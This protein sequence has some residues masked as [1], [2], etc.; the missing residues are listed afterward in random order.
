LPMNGIVQDFRR[1][2][3]MLSFQEVSRRRKTLKDTIAA[4][5]LAIIFVGAYL[6]FVLFDL[7]K[8]G[9]ESNVLE[10]DELFLRW[11]V[12]LI[13]PFGLIFTI[14]FFLGRYSEE[15]IVFDKDR[16]QIRLERQHKFY[17]L[18]RD[19][20][21]HLQVERLSDITEV[22]VGIDKVNF[23]AS[24]VSK[25]ITFHPIHIFLRDDSHPFCSIILSKYAG[26][27]PYEDLLSPEELANE[28][29]DFLGLK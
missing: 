7:H 27:N 11:I 17:H 20:P 22:K 29:R 16:N 26:R 25:T 13:F 10:L 12:I 2:D 19:K 9:T 6:G 24:G 15:K 28:I 21:I 1:T 18:D 23:A 3:S 5:L 8:L 4:V 14:L